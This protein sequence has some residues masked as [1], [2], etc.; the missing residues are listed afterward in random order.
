[1]QQI[2]KYYNSDKIMYLHN[3]RIQI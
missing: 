3:K 2:K 1:M